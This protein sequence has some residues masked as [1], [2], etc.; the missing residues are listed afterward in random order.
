MK[1]AICIIIILILSSL[2]IYSDEIKGYKAEMV[3]FFDTADRS[4]EAV[5]F[6]KFNNGIA[7]CGP[8]CFTIS[9]EDII[10]VCDP[11]NY[12]I[13][14]YDINFNYLG[15]IKTRNSILADR[16]KISNNSDIYFMCR[17]SEMVK[18]DSAGNDSYKM[19]ATQ[20]SS[21]VFIND[22][23]FPIDN[24][25]F[26]YD[27]TNKL[28][29]ID[30]KGKIEDSD[31]TKTILQQVLT[32]RS[33]KNFENT[34]NGANINNYIEEKGLLCIDNKV[35]HPDFSIYEKYNQFKKALAMG[36]STETAIEI[37][38]SSLQLHSYLFIGYD[39]DNNSYWSSL[40][41]I[42]LPDT[43][44]KEYENIIIVFNNFGNIININ[45]NTIS[46]NNVSVSSAGDLY[47]MIEGVR[48][49]G[50]AFYKITRRW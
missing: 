6:S 35:L 1:K 14:K 23:F 30:K 17:G 21:Q 47:F 24:Y 26:F 13:A 2:Q 32:S 29:L 9:N 38:L 16:I 46:H 15:E 44:K 27:S 7:G 18:M 4:K 50:V 28:R 19:Y 34:T 41:T 11:C 40:K 45:K 43:N 39:K 37:D 25:L 20:I 48:V 31:Q 36:K 49:G 12:R 8:N 42:K 22:N 5:G 33:R 10:Y 3:K